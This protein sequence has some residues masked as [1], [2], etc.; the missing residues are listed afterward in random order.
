MKISNAEMNHYYVDTVNGF[1]NEWGQLISLSGLVA[2]TP[3][4]M[5]VI[6]E[7]TGETWADHFLEQ[8]IDEARH[9]YAL[10]NAAKAEVF[11]SGC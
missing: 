2:T 5:Q 7:E 8:A 9:V 11:R 6:D 4:N 3:L 1:V 10:Y